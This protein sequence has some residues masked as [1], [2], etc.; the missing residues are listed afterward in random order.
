M[1]IGKLDR[2]ELSAAPLQAV[3]HIHYDFAIVDGANT[4]GAYDLERVLLYGRVSERKLVDEAG[5]GRVKG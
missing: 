1:Q 4:T 5:R 3:R 2:T